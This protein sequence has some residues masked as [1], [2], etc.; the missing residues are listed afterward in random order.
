MSEWT[1][2][3]MMRASAL[4]V[5]ALV[6]PSFAARA[7]TRGDDL[8]RVGVIGCG[9][10][11]TGAA[12]NALEADPSVRIVAMAD[13]FSDRLES[14]HTNLKNE[15][16][17]RVGVAPEHRFAGFDGYERLLKIKEIDY[18][19]LATPPHFRPIHFHAAVAAGKHV[20]METMSS[21]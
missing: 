14:S 18:V 19:V 11:G 2:R 13:L 16:S 10:R 12:W 7:S 4:G 6:A 15:W 3:D 17:E 8:I 5:G 1:R 21:R 20:F 9:G